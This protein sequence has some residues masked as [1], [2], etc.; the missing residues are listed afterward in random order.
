VTTTEPN[1]PTSPGGPPARPRPAVANPAN[2][3]QRMGAL[4]TSRIARNSFFIAAS[5][6]AGSGL[7]YVYWFVVAR[8]YSPEATGL[9]AALVTAMMATA[10]FATSGIGMGLIESLPGCVDDRAWSRTLLAGCVATVAAGGVAGMVVAVILPH[11]SPRLS[12]LQRPTVMA[13][14]VVGVVVTGV[15]ALL[16]LAAV[17]ERRSGIQLVRTLLFNVSKVF[18]LFVPYIVFHDAPAVLASWVAGTAVSLLPAWYRLARGPR[19]FT[20]HFRGVIGEA[21][22]LWKSF[23]GHHLA[24]VGAILAIYVLPT[25]V[26]S[27]LGAVQGAYFYTTWM[28]GSAF[29]MISPAVA[30]TLFAEGANE[31]AELGSATRKCAVLIGV[32]LAPLLLLYLTAGRYL[33]LLF[34]PDYPR[35]GRLLLFLLTLSAIPDAVTNVAVSV[36]R[37]LGRLRAAVW[38]N[39]GMLVLALAGSWVLLPVMGIAGVGM[40]WLVSQTVGALAVLA[41]PLGRWATRPTAA[42][43][44]ETVAIPPKAGSLGA[45]TWP[46]VQPVNDDQNAQL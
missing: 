14:F 29:F 25:M 5:T 9:S 17:A 33:L 3:T 19:R 27:R 28:L 46:L 2:L 22:R 8:T 39:V 37:A 16:D 23:V 42:I 6:F 41:V 45:A 20:A 31:P 26:V 43:P 4:A 40:A 15:G 7:G 18:A 32:V 24:T 36:L 11:A 12:A 10:V 30:S 34:G 35:H 1:H 38:L 44:P 13:C 21:G